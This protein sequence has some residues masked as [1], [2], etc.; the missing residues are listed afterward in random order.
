MTSLLVIPCTLNITFSITI[1]WI[2]S[3]QDVEKSSCGIR[4]DVID[5]NLKYLSSMAFNFLRNRTS[6]T[7]HTRD[8]RHKYGW[9]LVGKKIES[10]YV[11]KGVSFVASTC[12]A[13]SKKYEYWMSISQYRLCHEIDRL[14]PKFSNANK[15]NVDCSCMVYSSNFLSHYLWLWSFSKRAMTWG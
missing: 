11:G 1:T 6:H 8:T 13:C 10:L 9:R 4:V 12:Q 15:R 2:F 7:T 14:E 3:M 5:R